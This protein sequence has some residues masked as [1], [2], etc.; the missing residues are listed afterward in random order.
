MA[1]CIDESLKEIEIAKAII[2]DLVLKETFFSVDS[3]A[4]MITV[5]TSWNF[6]VIE[7]HVTFRQ[8]LSAIN[9]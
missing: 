1:P 4:H 5:T 9:I 6:K 2:S 7:V 8:Q 3:Y